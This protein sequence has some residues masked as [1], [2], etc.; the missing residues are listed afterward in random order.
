MSRAVLDRPAAYHGAVNLRLIIRVVYAL[1]GVLWLLV[2]IGAMVLP[3]GW[4]SASWVGPD[5]VQY[6]TAAPASY[7]NHLTQE[8]GTLAI[9]V[10]FAFL[11]QGSRSEPSR[12]L[13]WLLTV[14]LMLDSLIHWV[15]PQGL[16]GSLQRGV[17]NSI[18]PLVFLAL[19]I[20]WMRRDRRGRSSD[21]PD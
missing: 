9:A 14:Y 1:L 18:P 6:E 4:V 5:A 11:W 19:G 16:I 17:I 2:G 3:L 15:G 21:R 13:H 8:F 10:A 7:L 12:S 20:L